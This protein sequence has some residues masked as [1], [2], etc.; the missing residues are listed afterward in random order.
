MTL[1]EA[2]WQLG[3][4]HPNI[5]FLEGV[6]ETLMTADRMIVVGSFDG[7][8]RMIIFMSQTEVISEASPQSEL[9]RILAN[10]RAASV[11]ID[12]IEEQVGGEA[13]AV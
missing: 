6:L 5:E 4:D 3:P 2:L 9:E 1:T 7:S 8:D 11:K 10:L 13:N 12:R